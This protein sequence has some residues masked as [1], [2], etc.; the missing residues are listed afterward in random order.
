MRL[1]CAARV[2]IALLLDGFRR[3]TTTPGTQFG[4]PPRKQPDMRIGVIA[5]SCLPLTPAIM[6]TR[7]KVNELPSKRETGT[8][9][10]AW[11]GNPSNFGLH[12][13]ATQGPTQTEPKSFKIYPRQG[14]SG[15]RG[16]DMCIQSKSTV[17]RAVSA[18]TSVANTCIVCQVSQSTST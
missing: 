11:N 13:E 9:L 16:Y 7:P 1:T 10:V 15:K 5:C 17:T 8:M 18:G 12:Q 2:S 14:Q 3:V 6:G 4:P